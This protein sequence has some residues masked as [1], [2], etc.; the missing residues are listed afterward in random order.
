VLLV[1]LGFEAAKVRSIVMHK[2]S[3]TLLMR[4]EY[5]TE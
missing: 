2:Q 5:L 1:S 3:I 4:T